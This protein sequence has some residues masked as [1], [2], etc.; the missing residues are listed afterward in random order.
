MAVIGAKREQLRAPERH[1]VL[2]EKVFYL[3]IEG[4]VRYRAVSAEG[5]TFIGCTP[6]F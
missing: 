2:P 4:A 1:I 6:E 3:C 5:S